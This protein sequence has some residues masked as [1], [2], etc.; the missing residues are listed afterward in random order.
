[1]KSEKK[2]ETKMSDE[3]DIVSWVVEEALIK[4]SIKAKIAKKE[5]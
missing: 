4:R 3:E 1:M 2:T 5:K